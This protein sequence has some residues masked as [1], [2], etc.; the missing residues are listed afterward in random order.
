MVCTIVLTMYALSNFCSRRT[1]SQTVPFFY[2]SAAKKTPTA[3]PSA[4]SSHSK[5]ASSTSFT[6]K[7][8]TSTFSSSRAPITSS[9]SSTSTTLKALTSTSSSSTSPGFENLK[10][11]TATQIQNIIVN[12]T[13]LADQTFIASLRE[14]LAKVKLEDLKPMVR[15]LEVRNTLYAHCLIIYSI[16]CRAYC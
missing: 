15:N 12:L 6:F 3:T 1:I 5:P 10:N 14:S 4:T 11:K 7:A 8:A 16:L 9:S 13:R 2:S